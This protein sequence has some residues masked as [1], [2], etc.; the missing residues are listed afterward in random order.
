MQE[1]PNSILRPGKE[2]PPVTPFIGIM[3]RDHTRDHFQQGEAP[4]CR[5]MEYINAVRSNLERKAAMFPQALSSAREE[6]HFGIY[7]LGMGLVDW[8]I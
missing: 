1:V 7:S 6:D 2:P 3:N 5:G 4:V 8:L